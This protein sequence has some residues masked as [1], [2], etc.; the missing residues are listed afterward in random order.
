MGASIW[1]YNYNSL[2]EVSVNHLD[3][4]PKTTFEYVPSGS[5]VINRP[6]DLTVSDIST[7]SATLSWTPGGSETS[8]NVAYK[9]ATEED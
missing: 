7:N 8:W 6:T 1:G 3:F 2:D 9:K 4:G 5:V